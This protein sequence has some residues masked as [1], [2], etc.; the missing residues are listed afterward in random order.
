MIKTLSSGEIAKSKQQHPS[1]A[2]VSELADDDDMLELVEMFVGDL[3]G[4][5]AAI[6]KAIDGR[7]LE[8]LGVMA[9]QMKGAAGGYGFPTMT[10]AARLLDA[11]MKAGEELATIVEQARALTDLCNRACPSASIVGVV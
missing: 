4:K 7:D 3:P 2:L 10:D 8:T 11:S 1:A 6:E 9:H 5:V